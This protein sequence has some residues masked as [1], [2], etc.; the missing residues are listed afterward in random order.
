MYFIVVDSEY[1]PWFIGP[2]DDYWR[3]YSAD[4]YFGDN[5]DNTEVV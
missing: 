3:V 5:F 4:E 2:D 1:T